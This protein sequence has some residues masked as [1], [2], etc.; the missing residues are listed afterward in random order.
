MSYSVLKSECRVSLDDVS[1]YNE[2]V[3]F[4]TLSDLCIA[5]I[6]KKGFPFSVNFAASISLKIPDVSV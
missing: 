1:C 4:A 6:L 3:P 5:A 2:N